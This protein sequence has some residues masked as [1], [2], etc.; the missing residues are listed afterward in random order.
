MAGRR[1]DRPERPVRRWLGRL[2]G[3]VAIALAVSLLAAAGYGF[4]LKSLPYHTPQLPP[5]RISLTA[6]EISSLAQYPGGVRGVPVLSWRDVSNRP[7]NLVTTPVRFATEL[8]ILRRDGFASVRL[9]ALAALAAGRRVSLPARPIVLTFDDGLA[10]DWTTVDPILKRYGFTAVVFINP[11]DLALKSPSY[12]LTHDELSEMAASGRWEVGLQLSEKQLQLSTAALQAAAGTPGQAKN[13]QAVESLRKWRERIVAAA[14]NERDMLQGV[15]GSAVTAYGWP[16]AIT[17]QPAGLAAPG[18]VY[19]LL[20]SMFKVAF[21]RPAGGPASFVVAG[22]AGG[23]LSRLKV[24][25]ASTVWAVA[26]SLTTGVPGPPP[27]DPLVLP[28]TARNGRCTYSSRALNLTGRGFVLCTV[29]ADGSEWRDYELRLRLGFA[30][31][32][33][34]TALVELRL[35]T[36]GRIEIA[37][38]RSGVSVKQL[39]GETWSLLRNVAA[40]RPVAP[41]GS[42]MSFLRSGA[43]PVQL[44]IQGGLLRI[45]VGSVSTGV[46]VSPALENGVI[47]VGLVS[48]GRRE[49]VTYS[50]ASFSPATK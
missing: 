45:Q 42:T 25:A 36:A 8:A 37:I 33:N 30:K 43:L 21:G 2:A 46:R 20:H 12:F 6:H 47:A 38:G 13:S 44:Q 39:V 18:L 17:P 4:V 24:T 27:P 26:A 5:P 11:Q 29:V 15:A 48:P 31:S 7:G 35:T 16:V 1:R 49:T 34:L 10:T 32:A 9:A 3:V 28:W 14:A 40:H 22:A 23:P 19:P 41:D 50:G